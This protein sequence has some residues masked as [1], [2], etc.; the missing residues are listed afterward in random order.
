MLTGNID[1]SKIKKEITGLPHQVKAANRAALNQMADGY[2]R[3][4]RAQAP[5][6]TGEYS[7]SWK[8]A[9][10]SAV[11]ATIRS[12]MGFLYQILEFRGA[13]P[14]EL[15]AR[16]APALHWIDPN[17]G[18][19]RFALKVWHPGFKPRPHMRPLMH[20][21]KQQAVRVISHHYSRLGVFAVSRGKFPKH[22]IRFRRLNVRKPPPKF[23]NRR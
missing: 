11:R 8:K 7:R 3:G 21:L 22:R 5:L 9:K 15:R 23:R 4:I 18:A 10:V 2:I 6:E 20:D 17:T 19:H 1:I 12:P 16:R 13:R 14:H